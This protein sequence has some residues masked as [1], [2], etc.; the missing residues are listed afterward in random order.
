MDGWQI[1]I[2]TAYTW[3]LNNVMYIYVQQSSIYNILWFSSWVGRCF[4]RENTACEWFKC[5]SE[6]Q[7]VERNCTVL[8]STYQR[9]GVG[10][11]CGQGVTGLQRC[12]LPISWF[13]FCTNP[14][15]ST[16]RHQWH[17]TVLHEPM[18]FMSSANFTV[19]TEG[20]LKVQ[21]FVYSENSRG[22]I[23]GRDS[24]Q[25]HML[26]PVCQNVCDPLVDGCWKRGLSGVEG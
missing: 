19:L 21:S 13:R 17:I 9:G 25:L 4:G 10:T 14:E 23:P 20:S 22:D 7:R 16:S 2:F 24:L 12:C 5:S 26:L 11:G 15:L 6:W 3:G 8:C 18:T 1:T